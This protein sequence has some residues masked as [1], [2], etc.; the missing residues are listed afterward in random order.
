M[1]N[2]IYS[3]YL[4]CIKNTIMS[5]QVK[6]ELVDALYKH[7]SVDSITYKE[8]ENYDIGVEVNSLSLLDEQKQIDATIFIKGYLACLDPELEFVSS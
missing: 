1:P 7:T 5:E 3:A 4:G 8:L 6:N 2:P